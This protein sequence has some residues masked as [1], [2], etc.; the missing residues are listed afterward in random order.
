MINE[1]IESVRKEKRL[2]ENLKSRGI[3]ALAGK[4]NFS[5][6]SSEAPMKQ[7]SKL[8]SA[9]KRQ[10]KANVQFSFENVT[11]QLNDILEDGPYRVSIE[12]VCP[13]DDE[14]VIKLLYA[15]I[16]KSIPVTYEKEKPIKITWEKGCETVTGYSFLCEELGKHIHN[17][18]RRMKWSR[19]SEIIFD[20]M[21]VI[22][23]SSAHNLLVKFIKHNR[24]ILRY[25][26]AWNVS[27]YAETHH[28]KF[29]PEDNQ[30]ANDLLNTLRQFNLPYPEDS[31][32]RVLPSS[33]LS[34]DQFY[35]LE[36][37]SGNIPSIKRVFPIVVPLFV[38]TIASVKDKT[39]WEFEQQS[40]YA[41]AF[42]D[43]KNITQKVRSAM[44]NNSFLKRYGKVELDNDTDLNKFRVLNQEYEDLMKLIQ[45]PVATDHSFRIRKLGKHR[46]AGIYFPFFK[47]T[48]F[49]L[50]HPDAYCHELAH[51]IDYTSSGSMLLSEQFDFYPTYRMYKDQ[52][53]ARVNALDP[54][55]PFVIQW[56]G[57]T[58]YNS[59]YYFQYTEVFARCFELFLYHILKIESSFL[60]S[61]YTHPVYPDDLTLLQH[62]E[63]YFRSL[64]LA[65]TSF[66]ENPPFSEEFDVDTSSQGPASYFEMTFETL[67]DG[68]L[69]FF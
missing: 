33:I 2:T 4:V 28:A 9:I 3:G 61:D 64:K 12:P 30:F 59:N 22:A 27:K 51:Q 62:I 14:Y 65:V 15:C 58:K 16:R 57:K 37:P 29:L 47:A 6:N 54:E 46:A 50:D 40:T 18:K 21:S 32:H 8:V 31:T 66:V 69:A 25:H 68:Q 41:K 11:E 60:K 67:E 43:K 53:T 49:D 39:E 35:M 10:L 44:E 56:R 55:D 36:D 20:L 5:V 19:R 26:L 17:T 23:T 7:Y 1:R 52:V 63:H 42:E 45:I 48:V 13:A 38:E 24:D 34:E